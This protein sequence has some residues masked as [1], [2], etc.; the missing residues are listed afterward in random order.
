M[1]V[2]MGQGIVPQAW[3]PVAAKLRDDEL[4]R[5]PT[6]ASARMRR[7]RSRASRATPITSRTIARRARP[8]PPAPPYVARSPPPGGHD[9]ARRRGRPGCSRPS[10]A[11]STRSRTS[12]PTAARVRAAPSSKLG[13]VPS[14]AAQRM[15][16]SRSI[17][18]SRS[19]TAIALIQG[20]I[21]RQGTDWVDQ[22]LLGA[23]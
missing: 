1:Q 21:H 10:A 5:S 17:S 7:G 18:S 14:L 12:G 6:W 22:M 9:Q 8:R 11:S 3:H 13:Y 2:M 23:C 16:G 15:G 19:T 4:D 20:W